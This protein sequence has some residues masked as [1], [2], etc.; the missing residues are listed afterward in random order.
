MN[1]GFGHC[2]NQDTSEDD[3]T[4]PHCRFQ[5]ASPVS[6]NNL[7]HGTR[8]ARSCGLSSSIYR[9]TAHLLLTARQAIKLDQYA[10]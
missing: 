7:V 1:I 2:A 9:V 5:Q 10:N 6:S 4:V 3:P 8:T